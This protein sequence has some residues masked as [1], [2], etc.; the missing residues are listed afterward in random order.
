M[1]RVCPYD[2]DAAHAVL[3]FLDLHDQIEAELVRGRAAGGL[4]LF[5]DWRAM[6]GAWEAGHVFLT[7]TGT[8]FAVGALVNTGQAGV[9][10]AALLA[11]DHARYR[12][13]LAELACRI[14]VELPALCL[15]RGIHRVE[16]RC[17]AH[18]PTASRFLSAL[19][20][21]PEADLPGFGA[22]GTAVFRQFALLPR[23]VPPISPKGATECA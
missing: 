3:A 6:R 18:H 15:A 5:A 11:R 9:A 13:P 19:G 14:A 21:V 4:A 1:I 22:D 20:F 8:P 10:Q 16:A 2:D 23:P 12:R 17:W 7:A